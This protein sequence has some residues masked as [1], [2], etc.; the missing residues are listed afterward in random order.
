MTS[1]EKGQRSRLICLDPGHGGQDPGAIADDLGR[2]KEAPIN[3][4]IAKGLKE[5][6]EA[7]GYKV[8]LTRDRDVY[9]KLQAR[10]DIANRAGAAVFVSIHCDAS[11]RQEAHG[12]T[13]FHY[14]GSPRSKRLAAEIAAAV[15][16][17]I[18]GVHVRGVKEARL[19]V[20]KHT[21][22]PSALV[23]CG[24]LTNPEERSK[25]MDRVYQRQL[26]VA[27][28]AGVN[29]YLRGGGKEKEG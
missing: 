3:L 19:Y 11:L 17:V 26:A 25:L 22:M 20:L 18:P 15:P 6:L 8:L 12:L 13:V 23:E 9:V 29:E 2:I 27:I 7:M 1:Q 21:V 28:A 24:F 4:A 10:C 5:I 16:T 14:P